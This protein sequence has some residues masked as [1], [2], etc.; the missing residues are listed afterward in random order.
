MA[1]WRNPTGELCAAEVVAI[2]F[3]PED[4]GDYAL[5]QRGSAARVPA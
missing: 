3:Q 4:S 5:W 1:R 2:L